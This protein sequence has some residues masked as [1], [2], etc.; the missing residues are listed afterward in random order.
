MIQILMTHN[1][2][3]TTKNDTP[4]R[5]WNTSMAIEPF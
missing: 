5:C 2:K 1:G 4:N 3:S